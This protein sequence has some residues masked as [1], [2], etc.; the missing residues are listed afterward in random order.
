MLTFTQQTELAQEISGFDDTASTDRFKRDINQGGY[1]FLA[2]LGRAFNRHTLLANIVADQQDYQLS[3]SV[4]RPSEF[5]YDDGSQSIPLIPVHDETSWNHM[6]Q[7]TISGTPSHCFV[8]GFDQ[9][10]LYPIPSASVTDGLKIVFEPKHIKINVDDYTTGSVTV[11]EESRTITHSGTGFSSD[12]IGR[13]FTVEDGTDGRLYRISAFVSSSQLT[14]ENYYEGTTGGAKTFRI[15]QVMDI[16]EEYHEAPVDYAMQRYWLRRGDIQKAREF[17]ALF[18]SARDMAK[19][20]YGKSMTSRVINVRGSTR[21]Y[22]PMTDT[23]N[24]IPV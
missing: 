21:R 15:G 22:N 12:M 10:S 16:P 1:L 6:N 4:L 24:S 11:T 8:K 13:V 17:K 23:P 20:E 19:R 18:D 9:V 3:E 7:N 14:L 5:V 2:T